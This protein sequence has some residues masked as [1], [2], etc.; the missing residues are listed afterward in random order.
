MFWQKQVA[1]ARRGLIAAIACAHG[2]LATPTPTD[3]VEIGRLQDVRWVPPTR[4]ATASQHIHLTIRAETATSL[5]LP[6]RVVLPSW[7]PASAP[8]SERF[9]AASQEADGSVLAISR[10]RLVAFDVAHQFQAG[11]DF[12][13]FRGDHIQLHPLGGG[14][15]TWLDRGTVIAQ[16]HRA[17]PT[18]LVAASDIGRGD[19][20][21]LLAVD[22][23]TGRALWKTHHDVVPSGFE[24]VAGHAIAS[25]RD[26]GRWALDVIALDTGR[27]VNRVATRF[28]PYRLTARPDGSLHGE[29]TGS[30]IEIA[31]ELP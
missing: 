8:G 20:D 4:H 2:A 29:A 9:F 13:R 14:D 6:G 3:R 26:S 31:V 11:L 27:I 19:H 30:V 7:L 12:E 17:G 22:L 24:V 18:V 28:G 15:H 21:F 25:S 16:A 5:A 23:Q 10:H 1:G